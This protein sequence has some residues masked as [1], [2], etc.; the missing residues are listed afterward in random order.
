MK[1]MMQSLS[2]GYSIKSVERAKPSPRFSKVVKI[3]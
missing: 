1:K 2:I 3:G